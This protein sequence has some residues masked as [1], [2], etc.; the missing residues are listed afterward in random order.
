MPLEG[1]CPDS[2][3]TILKHDDDYSKIFFFFFQF[4]KETP[5]KFLVFLLSIIFHIFNLFFHTFV[6]H[7]I[8]AHTHIFMAQ[9]IPF[10]HVCYSM[11]FFFFTHN[12]WPV[13]NS[14]KNMCWNLPSQP[15]RGLGWLVALVIFTFIF[16]HIFIHFMLEVE[17]M[18]QA[19]SISKAARGL[20]C[21]FQNC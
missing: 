17:I 12:F 7:N 3:V 8:K 2:R 15:M 1:F 20:P 6:F 4:F 18:Y 13:F 9:F 16:S 14:V 11:K 21:V 19:V 10:P 5:K